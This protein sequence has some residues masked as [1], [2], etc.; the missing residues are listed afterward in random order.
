MA[1]ADRV[2]LLSL[3]VISQSVWQ[4]G[5]AKVCTKAGVG[6]KSLKK[7]LFYYDYDKFFELFT[8]IGIII[9]RITHIG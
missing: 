4:L 8:K 2:P 9:S 6:R 1:A 3:I 7:R 5:A